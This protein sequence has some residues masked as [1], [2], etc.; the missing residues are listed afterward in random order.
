MKNTHQYHFANS[1]NGLMETYTQEDQK[2]N[3]SYDGKSLSVSS[4]P[5]IPLAVFNGDGDEAFSLS[6]RAKLLYGE[7]SF[8]SLLESGDFGNKEQIIAT[9]DACDELGVLTIHASTS[10]IPI[11][12]KAKQKGSVYSKL[13]KWLR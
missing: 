1:S 6:L 3:S 2:M 9:L 4:W 10:E 11:Q 5:N 13:L 7:H 12:K 8:E